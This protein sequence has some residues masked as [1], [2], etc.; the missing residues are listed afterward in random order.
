MLLGSPAATRALGASIASVLQPGDVVVLSG[1][2]GS[3]KTTLV[4][5]LVAALETD[6]GTPVSVTSP[7]FALCHLYQTSPPVAHVDC[8]RLDDVGDVA[9]L[10]LEEVL[11]EGGV[12][13]LEWGELALALFGDDALLVELSEGAPPIDPQRRVAAVSALGGRW[14]ARLEALATACSA[15]GLVSSDP[16]VDPVTEG[17]PR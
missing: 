5:G 14:M 11:D 6:G 15:A 2:L 4:A 16:R 9:D 17:A 7:T 3:G 12:V 8:W 13:V 10:G 1:E